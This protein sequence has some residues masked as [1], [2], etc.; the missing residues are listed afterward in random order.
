MHLL[1]I[2][3]RYYDQLSPAAREYLIIELLAHGRVHRPG[4]NDRWTHGEVPVDWSRAG[5]VSPLG[6][7]IRIGETENHIL[8]IL[9]ARYLTNQ[10][11][12]QRNPLPSYDNRRN[13]GEGPDC[14][15]LLLTLLR[16]MLRDDFSEYNAKSYQD[17]TRSALLNLCSYAYDH[18]V[19]LASRMVLDYISAHI[20][21]SSCDLRR[22][23]PFRR[24]NEGVNSAQ[25]PGG[26][27]SVGLLEWSLGAD[28]MSEHFA[29]QAG[30][31]RAYENP[32]LS[33]PWPWGIASDG[34]E[35]TQEALSD[36]RI[37]PSIHDL[38]VNDLHRRF[39]QRLHRFV[40]PD[41]KLTGRNCDNMEIYAGSPSYLITAGGSPATYAIDPGPVLLTAAGRRKSAQQ[42][43][44]AVTTSFMPAGQSPGPG[45][46]NSARELIQFSH[47]SENQGE[48]ANYGVAPDLAFG[49]TVYLPGWCLDAID[50]NER[51][52]KFV[53]VNKSDPKGGPGFYLALLRDGDFT[54]MEAF[55]TWLHPGVTF[56]QFRSGVWEKNKLLSQSGLNSNVEFQ[57]TTQNGNQLRIVIWV[58]GER[59]NTVF[60]A[61]V[62]R[63][64]YGTGDPTDRL[65]DAGNNTQPFL[66]GTIMNSPAEGVVEITNPYLGT[67][68]TLDMRDAR[69]PRRISENGEIEEA[70][71]QHEVWVDFGWNGASEGD[72]FRPFKT[73]AA[74]VA[75]VADRGVIKFMP[76]S[77]SEK[78]LFPPE[79]KIDLVAPIGDVRIGAP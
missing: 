77:T 10:L 79:K 14:M 30:N 3:Y 67:K 35:A 23:V 62:L 21:V 5:F 56:D 31:T 68:I 19:R 7:E 47:F 15:G 42:L 51:R 16:D 13:A 26:I 27:M 44:V 32:W 24:R 17:E 78:P 61:K 39:F 18:E 6:Y 25:L 33:R 2:A 1:P 50:I 41:V 4:S 38:F 73:V 46:Q 40:L 72:F 71:S 53:F 76:G 29:I 63:I 11:L 57:Y 22:L 75:A 66:S 64:D 58:N 45:S 36:Y 48:V 49:H 69:H 74:A 34:G 20:A 9:T 8:M 70:G 28:P 60:G 43:G 37:P 55:D 52:G 59:D 12:Y 65:G 54:V